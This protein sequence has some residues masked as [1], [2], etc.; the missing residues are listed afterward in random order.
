M[1]FV[2]FSLNLS[3]MNAKEYFYFSFLKIHYK[4]LKCDFLPAINMSGRR[5]SYFDSF[6]SLA[7]CNG[8]VRY[9]L[10]ND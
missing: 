3:R 9:N 10:A 8:C 2:C 6:V 7:F 5:S 4:S 1:V